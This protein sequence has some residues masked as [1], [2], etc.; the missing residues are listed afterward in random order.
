MTAF[1]RA[2]LGGLATA[3]LWLERLGSVGPGRWELASDAVHLAWEGDEPAPF[4]RWLFERSFQLDPEHGLIRLPA[5][6]GSTAPRLEVL[7]GLQDALRLTLLQH[8]KYARKAGSARTVS[9]EIDEQ[10]TLISVQPYE[11]YVHR[12]VWEEI[13]AELARP[14]PRP[15]QLAGWASPGAAQRHVA[16]GSTKADYSPGEA[17]CAAFALLGTL[18]LRAPR[19]GAL[20]IPVPR[21]L[22]RFARVRPHLTPR[23]LGELSVGGIGDAV[24][25][26]QLALRADSL[27]A[28]DADAVEGWAAILL[29]PTAWASQQKSRVRVLE[30]DQL[31]AERLDAFAELVDLLPARVYRAS[32][33]GGSAGEAFVVASAFRAFVA[34]NLAC[35]RPWHHGFAT[36]T[37]PADPTRRLHQR[38]DQQNKG[39]LRSHETQG[40]RRMIEHLD[41]AERALIE[42]V[43]TALR[44]RFGQIAEQYKDNPQAM[45]NRFERERERL[46]LAFAGAR[47]HEQVRFALADL[48]SRAGANT[49]LQRQWEE[50]LPL[51]RA[52]RW[53]AARDLSLVALAAYRRREDEPEERNDER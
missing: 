44:Q 29:R 26:T 4:L 53:Q 22:V 23:S 24:L 2:G 11:G 38:R 25:S 46:R 34:D 31:P 30:L 51:L 19:G 41:S 45:K 42:A 49:T 32:G 40:V 47:T 9:T 50:I 52:E 37:D 8:G 48:W 13:A 18:S 21:D 12:E 35:G 17:L 27:T 43:Q 14:A 6:E 10:P 20:I 16:F 28:R 7:A 5:V 39:A 36:A 15:L 1:L 3:L 33:K